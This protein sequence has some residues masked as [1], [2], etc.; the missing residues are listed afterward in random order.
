[1]TIIYYQW[2]LQITIRPSLYEGGGR[3]GDLSLPLSNVECNKQREGGGGEAR[4]RERA[5]KSLV[6]NH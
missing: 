6:L 5:V 3:T 4:E 1:M 2:Q